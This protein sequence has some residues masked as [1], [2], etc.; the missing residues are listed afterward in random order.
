MSLQFP[1]VNIPCLLTRADRH[2]TYTIHE[3]QKLCKFTKH[4]LKHL[5]E[6]VTR[7]MFPFPE[8]CL[9]YR[10]GWW[11]DICWLHIKRNDLQM[12]F[13]DTSFEHPLS[14]ASPLSHALPSISLPPLSPFPLCPCTLFIFS[15]VSLHMGRPPLAFPFLSSLFPSAPRP[16]F[17]TSLFSDSA[18]SRLP[19]QIRLPSFARPSFW[20][21][22][23]LLQLIH[24]SPS[25]SS[26]CPLCPVRLSVC[27]SY[28][29]ALLP[30]SRS[31]LLQSHPHPQYTFIHFT[32]NFFC[33]LNKW[34]ILIHNWLINPSVYVHSPSFT[35][36]IIYS[37][38]FN[39]L[40]NF[41]TR[42]HTPQIHHL[43]LPIPDPR[44][45]QYGA[46]QT[47]KSFTEFK[48]DP[49]HHRPSDRPPKETR[50]PLWL[51]LAFNM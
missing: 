19:F 30:L 44:V 34:F 6:P 18:L 23:F 9:W 50:M 16:P 22:V 13:K 40:V 42:I 48:A 5:G 7:P 46:G 47:T 21:T 3:S 37:C 29:L 20:T 49:L 51:R 14:F 17:S 43:F 25:P 4:I 12:I 31:L 15:L 39:S 35:F 8:I 27:L 2:I 26:V 36:N 41:S 33:L 45:P 10:V 1:S 38:S 28:F 32:Y 11:P 24:S